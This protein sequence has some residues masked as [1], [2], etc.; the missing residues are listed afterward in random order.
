MAA[1]RW[2]IEVLPPEPNTEN[3]FLHVLFTDRRQ[4]ARLLRPGDSVGVQTGQNA[5]LFAGKVGGKLSGHMLP[6]KSW[7]SF[8][9]H[10]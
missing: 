2:R 1:A 5:V 6:L 3:L 8:G 4:P 10:E 9:R 7:V